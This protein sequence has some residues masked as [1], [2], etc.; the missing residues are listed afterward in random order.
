[1][2]KNTSHSSRT[3]GCFQHCNTMFVHADAFV[4]QQIIKKLIPLLSHTHTRTYTYQRAFVIPLQPAVIDWSICLCIAYKWATWYSALFIWNQLRQRCCVRAC[5]TRTLFLSCSFIFL[6]MWVREQRRE[7]E[8]ERDGKEDPGR[9][10]SVCAILCVAICTGWALAQ[11]LYVYNESSCQS[12]LLS[13]ILI[14]RRV[15]VCLHCCWF[16]SASSP[17]I[18]S[19]FVFSINIPTRSMKK[20][21]IRMLLWY[22]RLPLKLESLSRVFVNPDHNLSFIILLCCFFIICKIHVCM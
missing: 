18:S 4:E 2:L 12:I 8:M 16:Q 22:K 3:A 19:R 13:G 9:R 10:C 7:N 20:K 5:G 6:F 1:M 14:E 17:Y 15:S 21:L 11:N